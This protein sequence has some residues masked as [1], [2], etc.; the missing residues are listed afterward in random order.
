[1]EA[2]EHAMDPSTAQHPPFCHLHLHTHYSLLDGAT[3]IGPLMDRVK[4]QG[5]SAVAITDHG[6]MFGAIEFY[7]AAKAAGVKPI[8][9]MRGV[10]G[11]RRPPRQ[12][13]PRDERGELSPAAAGPEPDRAIATCSAW[14]ASGYLEG[15]Y[16]RPRIDK[17]TLRE[18]SEGLICT[19]T[20]LG[21]GDSRRPC[22][23]T[24]GPR[25]RRSPRS[26][27]SIFGEDRFFI[28]LAGPRHPRAADRSTRSWWTWPSGWAW[29]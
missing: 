7:R 8:I 26:T 12:E 14:P 18:H 29:R 5:M 6:N 2:P 3:R 20:C 9:G 27:S 21:G 4:Q 28:E 22:S 23:T 10:H 25:P 15:F 11:P 19:S 16:Y 1:M 13:C 24:T 17:E